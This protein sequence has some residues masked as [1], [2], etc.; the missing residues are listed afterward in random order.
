MATFGLI[1]GVNISKPFATII[2]MFFL[3]VVSGCCVN[4]EDF[5]SMSDIP[6]TDVSLMSSI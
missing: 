6:E 3:V 5:E 2:N 4:V 1:A